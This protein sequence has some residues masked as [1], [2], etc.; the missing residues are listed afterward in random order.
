MSRKKLTIILGFLFL[1][2]TSSSLY[3]YFLGGIIKDVPQLSLSVKNRPS[4]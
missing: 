3:I 4:E 2:L 1:F